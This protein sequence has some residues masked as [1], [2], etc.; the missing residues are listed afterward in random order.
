MKGI[1]IRYER[2]FSLGIQ[3]LYERIEME[4][5]VP[6]DK[7]EAEVI[8]YAK[9]TIEAWHKERNPELA[10]DYFKGPEKVPEEIPKEEE[11]VTNEKKALD[12]IKVAMNN[13]QCQADAIAF[14]ENEHPFYLDHFLVKTIIKSKPVKKITNGKGSGKKN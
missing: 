6:P 3:Y 8:N 13:F 11:P 1:T 5:T 10:T 9:D 2:N 12:E 14:I 7:T 4:V